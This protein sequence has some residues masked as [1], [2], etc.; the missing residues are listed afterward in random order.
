MVVSPSV[1][2]CA[3]YMVR[4]PQGSDK[5]EQI[6][7]SGS[8][9]ARK[10][11]NS[12]DTVTHIKESPPEKTVISRMQL[13]IHATRPTHGASR[14]VQTMSAWCVKT[15]RAPSR[16]CRDARVYVQTTTATHGMR[17]PCLSPP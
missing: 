6:A 5:G 2:V 10:H 8:G 3:W 12:F 7:I 11:I 9:Y 17:I 14:L 1:I 16:H 15:L 13:T 4:H